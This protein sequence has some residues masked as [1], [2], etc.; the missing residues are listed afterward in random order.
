[1]PTILICTSSAQPLHSTCITTL[2]IFS[3]NSQNLQRV[4]NY[5]I[6]NHLLLSI[7]FFKYSQQCLPLFS[8][9]IIFCVQIYKRFFQSAWFMRMID[10]LSTRNTQFDRYRRVYGLI[11]SI[12]PVLLRQP[13]LACRLSVLSCA[14]R[15]SN[16]SL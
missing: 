4:T 12:D 2:F 15:Y 3:I 14:L 6:F 8:N 11:Y 13:C 10:N 9:N 7:I 1:M 16:N 5:Q